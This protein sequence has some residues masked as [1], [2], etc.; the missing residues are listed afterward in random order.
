MNQLD[1][2]VARAVRER[3]YLYDAHHED[4]RNTNVRNQTFE[5]IEQDLRMNFPDIEI[6]GM[7]KYI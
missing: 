6:N 7:C 1:I 4:Y 5:M 2:F 3:I